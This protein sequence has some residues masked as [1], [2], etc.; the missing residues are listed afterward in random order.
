MP[1]KPLTTLLAFKAIGLAPGLTKSDRMVACALVDHFNRNT[2]QCDPSLSTLSALTGFVERTIIR[3]IARLEACGLIRRVRHG[4][5]FYRNLYEP[6][7]TRFREILAEWDKRRR[8]RAEARRN[9]LSPSARHSSQECGDNGVTQTC[10]SIPVEETTVRDADPNK[11]AE[12]NTAHGRKEL[13]SEGTFKSTRGNQR[14]FAAVRIS[15]QEVV[16]VKAQSRWD[17]D[18]LQRFGGTP[19]YA[20]IIE[21][22]DESLTA[23]ATDAELQRPGGGLEYIVARLGLPTSPTGGVR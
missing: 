8:T 20:S 12:P 23:A 4:G 1:V 5:H 18:L 10:S 14:P 13:G 3:A 9:K 16:R 22:I 15:S 6:Q 11:I 2:G 19:T 7:W 21:R 17:S